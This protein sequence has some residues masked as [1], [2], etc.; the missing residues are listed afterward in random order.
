MSYNTSIVSLLVVLLSAIFPFHARAV[1][2]AAHE[3]TYQMG[4]ISARNDTGIIAIVGRS[5]S[6][7]FRDCQGWVY[8]EDYLV[9]LSHESGENTVLASH[10]ESWEDISGGMYSFEMQEGSTFTGHKQ[11]EGYATT[12]PTSQDA[13]A[14]FS[15]DPD[16]PLPLPDTVFFPVAHIQAVLDKAEKG[17][18]FFPADVFFGIEPDRAL[19]H[20]NTVIGNLQKGK[21][22]KDV[23]GRL[24]MKSY[25]PVH[26]AYFDPDSQE[27][28]PEYEMTFHLQ[29]NGIIAYYEIDYGDFSIDARLV[30]AKGLDRP[31]CP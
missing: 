17:E 21:K 19:K 8:S 22:N 27:S 24:A 4:L 10:F 18:T 20:T 7:L 6:K 1:E 12:P 26:T 11:F 31:D 2:L 30:N 25:Y 13:Q 5:N 15:L 14:F 9:E 3:A 28:V 23:L 29:P 16:R